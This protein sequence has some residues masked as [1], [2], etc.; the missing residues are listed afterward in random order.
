VDAGAMILLVGTLVTSSNAVVSGA[1]VCLAQTTRCSTT[2]SSGTYQ[3]EVP[4]NANVAVTVDAATY[5][6]LLVP[7]TTAGQDIVGVE[8]GMAPIATLTAWY[9]A[10]GGTYPS[11]AAFFNVQALSSSTQIGEAGLSF[12]TT[13]A[14]TLGPVYLDATGTPTPSLTA[15]SSAGFSIGAFTTPAADVTV[16]YAPAT[17]T[18]AI[19]QGF[20]GWPV[21]GSTAIRG[22]LLAGY[23][24]ELSVTCQ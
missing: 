6:P 13:P 20:F 4:A 3:L 10:A 22:P 19:N 2:D 17:L 16:T 23:M 7:L 24:T 11:S 8:L 5:A 18:C 21:A 9:S 15:T 12:A 1:K 14:A